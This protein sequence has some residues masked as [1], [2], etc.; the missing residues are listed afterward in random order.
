MKSQTRNQFWTT[1]VFERP[2]EL[3]F[4]IFSMMHRFKDEDMKNF[5]THKRLL[6]NQPVNK[7]I[8]TLQLFRVP[9]ACPSFTPYS[10]QP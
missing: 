2:A 1:P 8:A 9:K 10:I 6:K 3:S 7:Q 5:M 4:E